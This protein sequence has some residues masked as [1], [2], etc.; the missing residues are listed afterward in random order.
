MQIDW[1]QVE[2]DHVRQACDQH[3]AGLAVPS[4][5]SRSTFLVFNGKAY[6]A[7]FIRGLAYRIATGVELDPNKDY[8]G[9]DET[10]RFFAGLGFQ[11]T[12]DGSEP[13]VPISVPATPT[14][15]VPLEFAKERKYEPQKQALFELLKKQFHTVRIEEKFP[16][17][18]VPERDVLT[19]PLKSIF[20][21]LEAMRGFSTFAVPGQ[22][23]R[24]DFVI[25]EE[26][27]IVEYDERQH[28]TVQRAK[29]LELYPSE[30]KLAFDRHEWIDACNS[31]RATDPV[32]PHRD[33]QRAF[34][35]SLRDV[36][37]VQNGYRIVRFR[38]G[39]TD[40]TGS[41][42]STAWAAAVMPA[43]SLATTGMSAVGDDIKKIG[44][45]THD[46]YNVPDSRGLFD[47]SEHLD[48]INKLCDDQGC[49][50]IL[51]ALWT[52]DSSSAASR[53]HDS[54]FGG[55]RHVQRVILEVYDPP[56]Q[57]THVEIWSRDSQKPRIIKQRFSTS[58]ASITDK[59]RF[60]DDLLDR[61]IGSALLMICGETNIASLVRGLDEFYDPFEF[62][63][64]L[65]NSDTRL[66][67]NPIHDYMR[68]YEMRE[69]RRFYSRDRRTVVSVWNQGKKAETAVPWTV[70]HNGEE[71]TEQVQELET[72]FEDRPDIRI[73]VIDVLPK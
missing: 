57:P 33:E 42:A 54:I 65:A 34:Y 41:D 1:S 50:T 63:T 13:A 37:A 72:P 2:A 58:S 21:A 64:C 11:T 26:R 4:R 52:W 71:L 24:C 25:P 29:A 15:A 59:Q 49:D 47:Y 12:K 46:C 38:Q 43:K 68:R 20:D 32:P 35:D 31:I 9:G 8:S 5:P 73:G 40:W 19:D 44:L 27:L 45:V 30:L 55:L 53:T 23:L 70:F 17:L 39:V 10:V 66:I 69:K 6:P 18:V 28:F 60:L 62:A 7:K 56:E 51:Y 14:A 36:L 67:L 61:K 3:D 22:S 48:R 16:W